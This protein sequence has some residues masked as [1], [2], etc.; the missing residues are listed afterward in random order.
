[1]NN[2][3][4]QTLKMGSLSLPNRILMAPLT[5]CRAGLDHTPNEMM[6]TYYA[7]RATAG[8]LIAEATMIQEHNSAFIAEP[9]IYNASQIA[10]WRKVTSRVHQEGGRIFLQL[11]HG[12]RAC[13]PDMNSDYERG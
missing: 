7:Q 12:G 13:H 6:A 2:P 10:G 9:G 4:F 3:L 1:M 11:W 5:R 8:L